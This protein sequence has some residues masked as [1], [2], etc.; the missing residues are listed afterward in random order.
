MHVAHSPQPDRSCCI[1]LILIYRY[2]YATERIARA[3]HHQHHHLLP[4]LP[5]PPPLYLIHLASSSIVANRENLRHHLLS[6]FSQSRT[7]YRPLYRRRR[8]Y[9][10]QVR[11]FG[12]LHQIP[13]SIAIVD[14][15]PKLKITSPSNQKELKELDRSS[16]RT[17]TLL[18][19]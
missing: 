14:P 4:L 9:Q 6:D 13:K 8:S 10:A 3:R 12:L 11:V 15:N 19:P 7:T 1:L 17:P 18:Q 5:P 2:L 16:P